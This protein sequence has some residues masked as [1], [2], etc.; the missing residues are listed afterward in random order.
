MV[1]QINR[2]WLIA[3]IVPLLA[4]AL[5][6]GAAQAAPITPPPAITPPGMTTQVV[7]NGPGDQSQPRIGG[8]LVAYTDSSLNSGQIR[9]QH[10]ATAGSDAAIPSN[11]GIDIL[12]DVRGSTIVYTHITGCAGTEADAIFSFDT[13]TS[14]PPTEV[15]PQPCSLRQNAGIGDSTIAW[16]DFGFTNPAAFAEIVAY[17]RAT[18]TTT[19]LTNTSDSLQNVDPTVSP[20]GSVIAWTK[21]DNSGVC[22]IWDATRTGPGAWTVHQLTTDGRDEL[23]DTN[24]SVVVYDATRNGEQDVY[25]QPVGG[26]AETQL[27]FPG[28]DRHP[29]VSGNLITFEHRG[30]VGAQNYDV[31]T[32]DML[33]GTLYRI[34]NTPQD[35]TLNDVW[36]D[37]STGAT[38]VVWSVLSGGPTGFDVYAA[39]FV[40]PPPLSLDFSLSPIAPITVSVGGSASSSVTITSVNGFNQAVTL[41][42]SGSPSGVSTSFSPNPVTPPGGGTA[43]STMG[44]TVSPFVTPSTFTLTIAGTAGSLSHSISP[45]VTVVASPSAVS[46]V[47]GQLLTAGCI[48]NAGIG[49]ALTAK[50]AAAQNA[51]TAGNLKTAINILSAFID[52]V[53]A[54]SAKHILASCTVAGVT[55]NPAAV[56]TAD[57]RTII[58]SLTVTATPNPVTGSVVTATGS[59][60][61]GATLSLVDPSGTTLAT[62]PTDVTGFYFF[63]TTGLLSAGGTYSITVTGLPAGFTS[64]S[65]AVQTFTWAGSPISFSNFTLT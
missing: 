61:S 62:A 2:A 58:D 38:H 57:A 41:S 20:D 12:P 48:D 35:E 52:Q 49:N 43:S 53:Q 32:Y 24:G 23:P 45:T 37:P 17:D 15:A 40:V 31:Y 3:A 36:S 42:A 8:D 50:L 54:Q 22:N 65:P 1:R 27:A 30:T 47:V 55:F 39:S 16:E 56:L 14:G 64:S 29:T 9:Y 59:G 60:I 21:C 26:G 11:G 44:L 6:P 51:I 4:W 7:N 10:L 33:A 34:T 13:S 63:P 25:W 28:A 5:A 46:T 19:A 18:A